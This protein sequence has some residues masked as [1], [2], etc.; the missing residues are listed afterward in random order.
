MRERTFPAALYIRYLLVGTETNSARVAFPYLT[1]FAKC[2]TSPG[3]TSLC[4]L[5]CTCTVHKC[6]STIN[7][8]HFTSC[9]L[10]LAFG[11]SPPL[12]PENDPLPISSWTAPA[13]AS[14]AILAIPR[15]ERNIAD[16]KLFFSPFSLAAYRS[17]LE[18]Y[19]AET[20]LSTCQ[21]RGT[22]FDLKC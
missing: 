8:K 1:P 14:P 2:T 3:P 7:V 16:P 17:L 6:R 20:S 18:S 21:L 9:Y 12:F 22:T 15:F 13:R 10:L 11:L 5:L 4:P 19:G